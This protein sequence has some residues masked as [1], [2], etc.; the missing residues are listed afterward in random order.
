[1][2][3]SQTLVTSGLSPSLL[4]GVVIFQ[5]WQG[6]FLYIQYVPFIQITYRSSEKQKMRL[7]MLLFM[8]IL[9]IKQARKWKLNERG[10]AISISNVHIW[11]FFTRL[12]HPLWFNQTSVKHKTLAHSCH[13]CN[14]LSF[15][16]FSMHVIGFTVQQHDMKD[17]ITV[18]TLYERNIS[19]NWLIT[20]MMTGRDC[21][22]KV[23]T[24]TH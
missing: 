9:G 4:S 12:M 14:C 15:F 24:V 6:F 21:E 3:I 17:I 22:D 5:S 1:M 20:C 7:D 2:E 13:C 18:F 19:T 23:L 16:F 10:A 8:L 11:Y